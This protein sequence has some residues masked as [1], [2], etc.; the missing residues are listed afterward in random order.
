MTSV[1]GFDMA[2]KAHIAARIL[3]MAAA[4]V[5]GGASAFAAPSAASTAEKPLPVWDMA[6]V[7]PQHR[8]LR[9]QLVA[10]I[11]RGNIAEMEAIARKGVAL[12]PGD[13]T[14]HYNLACAL[15]YRRDPAAALEELE[16]AVSFGFRNAKA[17]EEDG[18]FRQIKDDPR[19]RKIVERAR[20][21]AKDPVPG[22]PVP[23]PF[24]VKYGGTATLTETNVVWDFE[25]GVYHG[26]VKFSGPNAPSPLAERYAASRPTSPER[27]LLAAWI[28]EGTAAG[29]GGDFYMN[30]D[31][32]H[33]TIRV[34]DFPLLS[35]LRLDA[36]AHAKNLD[37]SLPN[38][39][40]PEGNLLIGNMSRAWTQGPYWRSYARF[41]MT[42]PG[43]AA[44]MHH[45]YMN[46]QLWVFPST[47]DYGDPMIGDAF[48]AVAPYQIVSQ[49]A[50]YTD[51]PIVEA[52]FAAAAAMRRQTKQEAR[53]RRLLGPTLQWLLR[54]T[55]PGVTDEAAYLSS[56][57]HPVAFTKK[58]IDMKELVTRAHNLLPGEIPPAVSL[59]LVNSRLF[60]IRF[61]QAGRDYPDVH[62]EFL[63][64]T[65]SVVSI[66]LRGPDAKRSFII[67]AQTAPRR[68]DAATFAWRVVNG[69]ASA[70]KVEVPLGETVNG[71]ERGLAQ[72]TVDRRALKSRIDIAVFAKSAG[73]EFG[74]PSFISLNPVPH[75]TRVYDPVGR[76]VSIDY[77]NPEGRYTDP[78]I[79]LPRAWKDTYSYDG[80]GACTGFTRSYNGEDSAS[81]TAT[82]ER[83]VER[84]PDGR[85]KTLVKVKYIP[86]PTGVANLPPE[87]TYVDD[88]EPFDAPK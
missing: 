19:F 79:A 22:R 18:D 84:H 27:P 44:L 76:L 64:T 15:A 70:V 59:Q 55:H 40:L 7:W 53:S 68:D 62:S 32:N 56:V 47:R 10:A 80:S 69:D 48:P 26:L 77:S 46:N 9:Q 3:L 63:V 8:H 71:P 81:F 82:G 74:A 33:S 54:R 14:W 83:I 61:P 23:M 45:L 36:A 31:R 75:E 57:A 25:A 72:I 30:R 24:Y 2:G 41:T 37:S 39:L 6:R 35:S 60:P 65:P 50:S 34:S 12:I 78:L 58:D 21:T 29:N 13:A 88:G 49:G 67:Q 28:S 66:I 85:P 4:A 1:R 87:L 17:I 16:T 11:R 86:R 43:A 20:K 52:L 42:E 5:L 38:I 73:T 51:R